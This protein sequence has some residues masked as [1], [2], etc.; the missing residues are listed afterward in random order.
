MPTAYLIL[1]SF[2]HHVILERVLLCSMKV[3]KVNVDEPLI[4]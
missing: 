4:V 1:L 3:T 2:L